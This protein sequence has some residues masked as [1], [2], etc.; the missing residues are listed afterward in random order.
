M[1]EIKGVVVV[2]F[3]EAGE[4]NYHVYG[5]ESVRL[6]IV[7]ERA[8]HDRVFE[9]TRREAPTALRE[10]IP[11]GADIGHSGDARH[12]AVE[13]AVNAYMEGRPRL[14]VV[15]ERDDGR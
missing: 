12:A 6:F 3:D 14:S 1:G 13:H 5:D 15:R 4:V 9:W 7:D 11:D 10:M 8:P 2:Q